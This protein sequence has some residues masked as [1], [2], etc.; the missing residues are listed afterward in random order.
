MFVDK[1]CFVNPLQ[2][3]L[4]QNVKTQIKYRTICQFIRICTVWS[5][6]NYK[7]VG[8]SQ[9]QMLHLSIHIWTYDIFVNDSINFIDCV[10]PGVSNSS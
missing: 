10:A 4:W 5:G 6:K 7:T 9:E 2:M 1:H 8:F 3:I